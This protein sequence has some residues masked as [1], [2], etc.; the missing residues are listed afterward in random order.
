MSIRRKFK[1][2]ETELDTGPLNDILFILM[3]FFLII[4]TLANPN[5]IK[6]SNP[7]A[8]SDT[9]AKRVSRN[10][11]RLEGAFDFLPRDNIYKRVLCDDFEIICCLPQSEDKAIQ[12]VLCSRSPNNL[13]LV[14]ELDKVT[15]GKIRCQAYDAPTKV[16]LK[17]VL[18]VGASF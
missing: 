13:T 8:K 2:D 15:E 6:M 12:A 18:K 3:F 11:Q 9:K 5:V 1:K 17:G 7:K 16:V 4:S 10:G 14:V